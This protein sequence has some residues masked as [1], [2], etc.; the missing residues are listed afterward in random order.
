MTVRELAL[1]LNA[2]VPV[3]GDCDVCTTSTDGSDY[4]A[5]VQKVWSDVTPSEGDGFPIVVL[6]VTTDAGDYAA[7]RRTVPDAF[8]P[9]QEEDEI[10]AAEECA[11][12][13]RVQYA[14]L[15]RVPAVPGVVSHEPD[16]CDNPECPECQRGH[17]VSLGFLGKVLWFRCRQC[18][19]EFNMQGV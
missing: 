5:P 12:A 17:G 13:A 14:D 9:G 18:G 16:V 8:C 10:E 1:Q 15:S 19:F 7:D 11:Q 4:I 3:H 2:L 6:V